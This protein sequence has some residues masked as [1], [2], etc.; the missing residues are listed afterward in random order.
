MTRALKLDKKTGKLRLSEADVTRQVC[1][2]LALEGWRGVRM[3]V[4]A[5]VQRRTQD[6]CLGMDEQGDAIV[7]TVEVSRSRVSFGE[8]GMPDWLFI[9]YWC[10]GQM[11][12]CEENA[13]LIWLEIKAPGKEP[14]PHQ[15]AWHKAERA[16]G[17]LV[18]V[19]DDFETFRDWYQAIFS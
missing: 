7:K 1:D 4:G 17:A 12:N 16:R 8:P 15:L 2:F 9:K 6:V 19:V 3:N 18:K 13:D 14:K 5:R 10:D 11:I